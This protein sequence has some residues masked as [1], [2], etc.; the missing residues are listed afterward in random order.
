[1]G[2][3]NSESVRTIRDQSWVE[4]EKGAGNVCFMTEACV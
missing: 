2:V 4:V 3:L 1:M